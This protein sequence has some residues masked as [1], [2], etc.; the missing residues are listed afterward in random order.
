MVIQHHAIVSHV[1]ELMRTIE[2]DIEIV[3][4]R[5]SIRVELF[6][7][8]TD[9]HIFRARLWRSE[10]YRLTPVFPQDPATGEPAVDSA[11]ASVFMESEAWLSDD[12]R[13][14][15]ADNP[16]SALQVV[17]GD[18]RRWLVVTTGEEPSK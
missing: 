2:F 9:L 12:Y 10:M 5:F 17:L 7:S 11:D 3:D 4:D 14:F 15:R 16:E 6:R 1:F 18:F 13:E 8:T